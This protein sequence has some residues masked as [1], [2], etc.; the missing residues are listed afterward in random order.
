[1][2][3][4]VDTLLAIYL[5]PLGGGAGA[6]VLLWFWVARARPLRAPLGLATF[7]AGVTCL[8]G[9][10]VL[11]LHLFEFG[12]GWSILAAALFALVSAALF[13]SL[14]ALVRRTVER[15]EGLAD[16]V[17]GLASV[18]VAIEPGQVGA[19]TAAHPA[20]ALTLVATSHHD[21]IL[22]VGAT[23]VVTALR[24]G[25]AGAAVE[26]APLPAIGGMLDEVAG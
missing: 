5:L 25:A 8:G 22:P 24:S 16:L 2:S 9:A 23:V 17:G 15:R 21:H 11:A 26:V 7:A 3:V 18:V 6:A 14:G 1:M 12:P 10:G 19:V 4:G 13:G 20:H